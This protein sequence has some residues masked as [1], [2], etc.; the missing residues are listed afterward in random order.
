LLLLPVMAVLGFVLVVG[1]KLFLGWWLDPLTRK[2]HQ[3]T[4][5]EELRSRLSFFF[6][7]YGAEFLSKE[8]RTERYGFDYV[9][10]TITF[11]NILLRFSRGRGEFNVDIAPLE[12][13]SAWQDFREVLL[14]FEP[15]AQVSEFKDLSEFAT[16]LKQNIDSLKRIASKD[17]VGSEGWNPPR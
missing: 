5:M 17:H 11:D 9:I 10:E 14:S 3:Q 13:P 12:K 1:H 2:R 8:V 7:E 6:S 15:G 4:F 16:V